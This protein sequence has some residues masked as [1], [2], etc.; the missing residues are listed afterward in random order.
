L[1]GAI[2]AVMVVVAIT[3]LCLQSQWRGQRAH[4]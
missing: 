3:V 2:I 4:Q 1:F